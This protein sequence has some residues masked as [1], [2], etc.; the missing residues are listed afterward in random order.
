[1]IGTHWDK[2]AR[3]YKE[4]IEYFYLEDVKLPH[5]V[6]PVQVFGIFDRVVINGQS[7]DRLREDAIK[8]L[9]RADKFGILPME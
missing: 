6:F 5:D 4:L 9:S 3:T 1:M 7:L 2:D 8:M